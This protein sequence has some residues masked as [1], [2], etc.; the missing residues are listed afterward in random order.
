MASKYKLIVAASGQEVLGHDC[1]NFNEMKAYAKAMPGVAVVPIDAAPPE[2]EPEV[3]QTKVQ[4]TAQ[5]PTFIEALSTVIDLATNNVIEA[6]DM[7]GEHEKQ[8]TA[9]GII[10]QLKGLLEAPTVSAAVLSQFMGIAVAVSVQ[11]PK[12]LD[13]M[14]KPEEVKA[15]KYEQR[16]IELAKMESMYEDKE[17]ET[18]GWAAEYAKLRA[19]FKQDPTNYK[20][21]MAARAATKHMAE[22]KGKVL[23]YVQGILG[24]YETLAKSK[25]DQAAQVA[26][27][28]EGMNEDGIDFSVFK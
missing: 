8:T 13:K 25:N 10:S 22:G 27:A 14:P 23:A 21:Q 3:S 26:K 2:P 5:E 4:P 7:P 9:I 1:N 24:V 6:D 28:V 19:F 20:I 12:D 18:A 15:N 16:A 17:F 11:A